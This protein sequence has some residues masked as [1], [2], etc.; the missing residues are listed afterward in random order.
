MEITIILGVLGVVFLAIFISSTFGFGDALV[1]MPLLT[2]LLSSQQAAPIVA[3]LS[4]GTGLLVFV[5]RWRSVAWGQ[6][7]PLLLVA[8]LVMPLGFYAGFSLDERIMKL[9]LGGFVLAFSLYNLLLRPFLLRKETNILTTERRNAG[10]DYWVLPFGALAGFFGG[11]YNISGPPAVLYGTLRGW[12][13]EVF[14]VSLQGFFFPLSLTAVSVRA[15]GGAYTVE[16][17]WYLLFSL[18]VL[19]LAA[20]LGRWA[21]GRLQNGVLFHKLIHVLLLFLGGLLLVG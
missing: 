19:L 12:R 8:L 16:V 7:L 4:L 17:L 20:L 2:L 15:V 3:A 14:S 5:P 10:F 11:A 6:V 13:A 21:N 1:S 18:P 9:V